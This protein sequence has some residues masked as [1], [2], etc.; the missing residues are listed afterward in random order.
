MEVSFKPVT[1]R[2]DLISS[3]GFELCDVIWSASTATLSP[4]VLG[5]LICEDVGRG[6]ECL[7]SEKL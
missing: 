2:K 7:I 6:S 4:T 3:S 1:P 5:I